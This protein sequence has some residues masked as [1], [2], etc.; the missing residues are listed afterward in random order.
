MDLYLNQL[1]KGRPLK[2]LT[3][4]TDSNTIKWEIFPDGQRPAKF[5]EDSSGTFVILKRKW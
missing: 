2:C 1:G 3:Q 5:V 4:L